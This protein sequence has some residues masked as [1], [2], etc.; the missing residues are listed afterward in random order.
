LLDLDVF[1]KL[2]KYLRALHFGD[3]PNYDVLKK[4]FIE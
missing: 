2:F 3:T 4:L 1:L